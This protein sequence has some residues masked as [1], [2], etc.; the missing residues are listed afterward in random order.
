MCGTISLCSL[1][2]SLG[3]I[4]VR[5]LFL[6]RLDIFLDMKRRKL[7]L[8]L[9]VA[10]VA[11]VLNYLLFDTNETF[12]ISGV[13]LQLFKI[14]VGTKDS[15]NCKLLSTDFSELEHGDSILLGLRFE[16]NWVS[17]KWEG[18]GDAIFGDHDEDEGHCDTIAALGIVDEKNDRV[19]RDLTG[20]TIER[21]RLQ[22]DTT[23][24]NHNMGNSWPPGFDCYDPVNFNSLKDREEWYNQLS[25]ADPD[26]RNFSFYRLTIED[27]EQLFQSKA[28]IECRFKDGKVIS[29]AVF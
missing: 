22:I 19:I 13:Q 8:L 14:P 2:T 3:F 17:I 1:R 12:R 5:N 16:T 10:I 28:R 27:Y 9:I 18:I 6:V 20:Y 7:I 26:V 23:I 25:W 15:T 11:V 24:L 29:V 21:F 4:F